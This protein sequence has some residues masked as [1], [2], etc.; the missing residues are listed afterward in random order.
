VTIDRRHSGPDAGTSPQE[1]SSM[2]AIPIPI[3]YPPVHATPAATA[4]GATLLAVTITLVALLAIV[5]AAWV[6]VLRMRRVELP[7]AT[8]GEATPVDEVPRAA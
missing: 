3:L 8:A 5:V 6:S 4:G 7:S 2:I 1:V